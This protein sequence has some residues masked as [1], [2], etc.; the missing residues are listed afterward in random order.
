M[1]RIGRAAV[2]MAFALWP[3]GLAAEEWPQFRGL[4]GGL[5]VDHRD[6][7]D[8]WGPTTNVAWVAPVPGLGW[9]SPVVWGDHV[10]V[11]S[12]V[13]TTQQEAPKPG[14]YLGDWPASTAPHKW[15]VYDFDFRTGKVRWE[16][17]VS[18][19]PPP[20]PKHLKNSYASETPVTDG[21][22]VYAYFAGVGLFAFDFN[23]APV[24]SQPLPP[25][26][27]RNNW[28]TGGSP[29]VHNGRLYLVS[30]NDE[31]SF[32]AAFDGRTGKEV[33]RVNRQEGTNWSTPFVW[34]N[35]LR[36]EIVTT[37]SDL[38]RSYDTDGTL[39]WQLKGMSSITVPTP[40]ASHGMLFL[41]SGYL[42]EPLR[43]TYA[44]K[45]GASGDIS[46]ASGETSNQFIVWSSPTIAP[47]NP[48]PVV[49]GDTLYTL[50][51]RGFFTA[52][53]ARTGKELYGRQ[54]ITADA[55]GF[56]S[57]PW[58][59]N[60]KV[61]AMSEDGDTF[62]IQTGPE[63]KVV[64]RNSLN[65]MTLAT[66]AIARGSLFVRTASKLYRFTNAR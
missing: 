44:I 48:S 36:T 57:S 51:D 61:F 13:S 2:M 66:P 28:G 24:W 14:Y 37:G 22:R 59:Y 33:W 32:I 1:T 64:G 54:R 38:V 19:A 16:R 9:S 62:V 3:A 43:P 20:L 18:A 11:T 8:T 41:S 53:D 10:F 45:P 60:G 55:S 58:S 4:A 15:T 42:P 29:A 39:L 49:A 5:A 27:T 52:H 56:T 25:K 23:G 12:V 26:K 40:F 7:P 47:Y 31:Q 50:L 17:Q 35:P 46:L 21:E 6:L 65:E 30:D 34:E 63:F